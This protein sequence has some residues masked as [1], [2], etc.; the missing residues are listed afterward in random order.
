MQQEPIK[1]LA[2]EAPGSWRTSL[3]KAGSSVTLGSAG[4]SDSSQDSSRPAESGL[5]MTR[6]ASSPRLSSEADTRVHEPGQFVNLCTNKSHCFTT[7]EV[8]GWIKAFFPAST[9]SNSWNT[10]L[11]HFIFRSQDWLECLLFQHG[12]S[13]VFQ[14]TTLTI[15]TGTHW[16]LSILHFWKQTPSH[17]ICALV[18]PVSPS[19][20]SR[21][22]S[23]TRRLYS[24]SGNELTSSTP[25]LLHR[26]VTPLT[27]LFLFVCSAVWLF[28][29][30][31]RYCTPTPAA[32]ANLCVHVAVK[33]SLMFT[34]GSVLL[35]AH[36]MER[37]W[38]MPL[39]PQ[40]VQEQ[41]LLDWT[42]LIVF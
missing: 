34:T 10:Q 27:A 12:N 11:F 18:T 23:Y 41:A 2:T 26:S 35:L 15:P 21:S 28:C 14:I 8:T 17:C 33:D 1:P 4:I 36:L 31:A 42:A 7:Q 24:Q 38:M 37:D 32:N 30:A 29:V 40:Q 20:L 5:G 16:L 25:S 6:S 22:S 39:W 13:S 3:R 19:W 9:L